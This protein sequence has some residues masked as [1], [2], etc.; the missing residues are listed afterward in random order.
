MP[1]AEKAYAIKNYGYGG[2]DLER[3]E[4]HIMRGLRNDDRL[5]K[6]GFCALLSDRARLYQCDGC[7]KEFAE[8][9]YYTQHLASRRH[10][11]ELGGDVGSTKARPRRRQQ[12]ASNLIV[13]DAED[14]QAERE[15][16]E[17][18]GPGVLADIPEKI[19]ISRDGI[20]LKMPAKAQE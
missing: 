11:L 2:Q 20:K 5:L 19:I 12:D 9:A 15:M 13:E 18:K 6:H 17:A 14:R 10:D 16:A 8:E 7:G 4:V 1:V 3:G